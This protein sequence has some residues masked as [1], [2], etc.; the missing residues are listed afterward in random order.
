MKEKRIK[1]ILAFILLLCVEC[2]IAIYVHDNFI[3][4]YV[5]DILVVIL[6]YCA[7]RVV[8]PEKWE[9]LPVW[10]FLFASFIE[11]LQYFNIVEK[12]GLAKNMFFRILIGTTFDWKDIICYG[13]GCIFLM[14]Y[15]SIKRKGHLWSSLK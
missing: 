15:Q 13:V 7:V 5:G 3:R 4:P 10:I 6:L 14:I 12:L 8:L 9:M 11:G 2:A 1:Y